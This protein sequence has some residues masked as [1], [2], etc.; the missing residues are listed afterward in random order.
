MKH[1]E[2]KEKGKKEKR[3]PMLK[4]MGMS[5]LGAYMGKTFA[6]TPVGSF[7]GKLLWTAVI[8]LVARLIFN[9]WHFLSITLLV[10]LGIT[11]TFAA[12]SIFAMQGASDAMLFKRI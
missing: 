4:R 1:N 12:F 3:A 7:I 11:L 6:S 8:G 5:F 10:I 2:R 9:F